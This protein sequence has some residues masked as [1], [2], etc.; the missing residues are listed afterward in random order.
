M[1]ISVLHGQSTV[2]N[3]GDITIVEESCL[4]NISWLAETLKMYGELEVSTNLV[5]YS[6]TSEIE[7]K[8]FKKH[9]AISSK[10]ANIL[11]AIEYAGTVLF[12]NC[13]NKAVNLACTGYPFIFKALGKEE[14]TSEEK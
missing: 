4:E 14:E 9:I 11:A 3:L 13:N 10:P 1:L 6:G 5:E 12:S 7:G 2:I 8:D